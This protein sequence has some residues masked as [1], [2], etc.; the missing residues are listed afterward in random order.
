MI[1]APF[2]PAKLTPE[3]RV[4]ESSLWGPLLDIIEEF[5]VVMEEF[6]VVLGT[7]SLL[8]KESM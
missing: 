7:N 2:G 5:F 4:H 3:Q 1:G 6:F 8:E